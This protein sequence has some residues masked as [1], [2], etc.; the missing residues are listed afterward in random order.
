MGIKP[1]LP[2]MLHR[3]QTCLAALSNFEASDI[4]DCMQG[5]AYEKT[6]ELDRQVSPLVLAFKHHDDIDALAQAYELLLP[7]TTQEARKVIAKLSL[8]TDVVHDMQ[9]DAYFKLQ[10]T[11]KNFEPTT[12]PIFVSF[13][14]TCLSRHLLS[15]YYSKRRTKLIANE[16]DY[17][18]YHDDL[19]SADIAATK[20]LVQT[21]RDGYVAEV[22]SWSGVYERMRP[23]L[24][25][26]IVGRIF[27]TP[28]EQLSQQTI[29]NSFG[30]TQSYV[31]KWETY[32]LERIREEHPEGLD[33]I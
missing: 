22:A 6:V 28:E 9:Q 5:N 3:R 10:E 13:W 30:V 26:I 33:N 8:P 2:L 17:A 11:A 12:C 4:L 32:F 29:A 31:A 14:R 16:L 20:L 19:G 27:I 21:M 7:I 15:R 23:M 24:Q 18:E 25:A 1:T